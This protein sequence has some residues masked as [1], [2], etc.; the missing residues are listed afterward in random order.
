ME[1]FLITQKFKYTYINYPI[2]KKTSQGGF[3][4]L[5]TPN[6]KLEYFKY[7]KYMKYRYSMIFNKIFLIFDKIIFKDFGL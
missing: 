5:Q 4:H 2:L 3:F 1:I 7:I 6:L